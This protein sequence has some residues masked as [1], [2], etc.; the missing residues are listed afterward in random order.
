RAVR[1]TARLRPAAPLLVAA[2]ARPRGEGD[3]AE[4]HAGALAGAR[5]VGECAPRRAGDCVAPRRPHAQGLSRLRRRS[6]R[7]RR[8]AARESL[9]LG[10]PP[11]VRIYFA[12]ELTDMRNG[13]DGLRALVESA[14]RCDPYEG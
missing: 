14:L 9:M 5:H 8:R 3:R 7:T 10:L 4:P 6:L 2:E 13:I 1:A 11:S 12:T